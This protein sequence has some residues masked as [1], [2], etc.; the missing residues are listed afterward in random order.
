MQSEGRLLPGQSPRYRGVVD[1][2]RVIVRT[3]GV[4]GLWT[5]LGPAILRNSIINATELVS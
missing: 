5:G 4:G 2:Y 1:A 3:E